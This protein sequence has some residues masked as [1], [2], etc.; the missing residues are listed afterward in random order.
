MSFEKAV[1]ISLAAALT[2]DH[3]LL[4]ELQSAFLDGAAQH[5]AAMR[6][7]A[8]KEDWRDAALRLQG[9][10]ASFGAIMLMQAAGRAAQG[11]PGDAALLATLDAELEALRR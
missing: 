4:G 11:A 2:G 6:D 10:G 5:L 1:P 9:L 3:A 7:A 8:T